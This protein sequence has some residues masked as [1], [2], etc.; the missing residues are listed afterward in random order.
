MNRFI[1]TSVSALAILVFLF[2][3]LMLF[4]IPYSRYEWMLRYPPYQDLQLTFCTLPL[5]NDLD[6]RFTSFI[7]MLPMF[8]VT[9]L[10]F[11]WKRKLHFTFWLSLALLVIW[12]VRFIIL[13]P[14]C[15]D[16]AT[17]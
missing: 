4:S 1:K 6:A 8:L 7:Y 15:P 16:R 5:D 2:S 10:F 11:A 12:F 9:L 17:F 13:F 3:G 14:Y